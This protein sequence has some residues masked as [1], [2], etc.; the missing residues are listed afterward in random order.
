MEAAGTSVALLPEVVSE[1][2]PARARGKAAVLAQGWRRALAHQHAY[3]SKIILSEDEMAQ[4]ERLIYSFPL[5]CFP[6]CD[7]SD[8]IPNHPDAIIVAEAAATGASLLLTRDVRTMDHFRINEVVSHLTH[9]NEP[10]IAHVDEALNE[11]HDTLE[12][13]REFLTIALCSVSPPEP[14]QMPSYDVET[15]RERLAAM[16]RA[17]REGAGMTLT[18]DR[19]MNLF[20]CDEDLGQLL[21]IAADRA[22]ASKVLRLE[23]EWRSWLLQSG[24]HQE[25]TR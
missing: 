23:E 20:D 12:G 11:A 8:D 16:T 6:V 22:A 7:D 21:T 17:I 25:F 19:L 24:R 4:R 13:E 9:R 5:N 3:F 10:L 15:T 14:D 2:T 1:L 18:A